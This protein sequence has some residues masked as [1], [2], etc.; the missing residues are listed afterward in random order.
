MSKKVQRRNLIKNVHNEQKN[1]LAAAN[2]NNELTMSGLL[3]SM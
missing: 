2:N 1:I 3:N